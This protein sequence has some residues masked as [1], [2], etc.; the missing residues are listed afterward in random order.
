MNLSGATTSCERMT[1]P[2]RYGNFSL[3]VS[4]SN[5]IRG[6]AYEP[7]SDL[8]MSMVSTSWWIFAFYFYSICSEPYRPNE[9][10]KSLDDPR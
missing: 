10:V 6:E 5:C 7:G 3:L 8:Y 1:L 4:N 2:V 9:E